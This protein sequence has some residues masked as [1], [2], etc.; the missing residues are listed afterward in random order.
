[1]PAGTVYLCHPFLVHAAQPHRGRAPRFIGQP[2][3]LPRTPLD[4]S[5]PASEL[6]AV[7]RAIARAL[8]AP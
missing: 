7:E 1:G 2:A 4:L 6:S 3:L 8:S 5:R